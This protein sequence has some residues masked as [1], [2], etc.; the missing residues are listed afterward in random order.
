MAAPAA[1]L[2]RRKRA[3]FQPCMSST[4]KKASVSTTLPASSPKRSSQTTTVPSVM[5]NASIV[6]SVVMQLHV[7][8]CG[9]I[10]FF[11]GA[12]STCFSLPSPPSAPAPAL[13]AGFEADVTCRPDLAPGVPGFDADFGVDG[14]TPAAAAAAAAAIAAAAAGSVCAGKEVRI[15]AACG[16]SAR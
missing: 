1:C 8:P 7:M 15:C 12:L 5:P 13:S 10:Q 4:I 3:C 14:F 2:P 16:C 9:I 6:P 11:A